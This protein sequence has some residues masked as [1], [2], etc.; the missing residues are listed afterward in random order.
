M[1]YECEC[2]RYSSLVHM[3]YCVSCAKVLC[4]N[5][6]CLTSEIASY[7]DPFTCVSIGADA[8][9]KAKY[10]VLD[11]VMCASCGHANEVK[12]TQCNFCHSKMSQDETSNLLSE[13]FRELAT[14]LSE[15]KEKEKKEKKTSSSL[16]RPKQ[17][18]SDLTSLPIS[19][20]SRWNIEKLE[21]KRLERD[22][23]VA[24]PVL[25]L[26]QV[27]SSTAPVTQQPQHPS[28][29]AKYVRRCR[30][31]VQSG[32]SG[33]VLKPETDAL[34]GDSSKKDT[35]LGVYS[36]K[37][38]LAHSYVPMIRIIPGDEK[39]DFVD[40]MLKNPC[41]Y[42]SSPILGEVRVRLERLSVASERQ[43]P[44]EIDNQ[45]DLPKDTMTIGSGETSTAARVMTRSRKNSSADISISQSSGPS[46]RIRLLNRDK[47]KRAVGFRMISESKVPDVIF[48]GEHMKVCVNI[49]ILL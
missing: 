44:V 24:E 40:I 33:L 6:E 2:G 17:T 28:L 23:R 31:C 22:S 7:Y 16:R 38:T 1:L 45:I 48:K 8:A 11:R 9:A 3:Y 15:K 39:D 19:H 14:R 46:V 10:R 43:L 47:S 34:E 26:P 20:S 13:R 32:R 36:E 5:L 12:S 25:P 49:L 18:W 42:E 41:V 30:E 21:S 29:R 37:E 35:R 27:A 4:S